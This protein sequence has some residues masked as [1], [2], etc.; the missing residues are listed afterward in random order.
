LNFDCEPCYQIFEATGPRIRPEYSSKFGFDN[1]FVA[2]ISSFSVTS[3][4]EWA[5]IAQPIRAGDSEMAFLAWPF[6]ALLVVTLNL[7]GVN[8]FLA[9]VTF[10]YMTV[11]KA[12]HAHTAMHHAYE[13]LVVTLFKANFNRQKPTLDEHGFE[14]GNTFDMDVEDMNRKPKSSVQKLMEWKVFDVVVTFT[15]IVNICCLGEA[16]NNLP[17]LVNFELCF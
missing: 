4:D 12:H 10:S 5:T 7:I 3:L 15:V 9:G 6:F 8:L 16:T 17:L 13:M 14:N 1:F 2:M 11:R